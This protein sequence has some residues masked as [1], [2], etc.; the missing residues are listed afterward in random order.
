MKKLLIITLL[1]LM[2]E[3]A[4]AQSSCQTYLSADKESRLI[5][6]SGILFGINTSSLLGASEE[7]I[8]SI[9]DCVKIFNP[10]QLEAISSKYIKNHPEYWNIEIG[11]MFI[12][13]LNEV[14]KIN[15]KPLK[16]NLPS[17]KQ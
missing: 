2:A 9:R 5:L 16:L 12:I 7:G 4:I 17:N 1:L 10:E 15:G 14:C 13:S 6:I 8:S 3:T 11:M